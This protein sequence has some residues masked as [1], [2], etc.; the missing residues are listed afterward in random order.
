MGYNFEHIA[1]NLCGADNAEPITSK[2]KNQ[3]P[4]NVVLCRECGLG[5]LNP[6]W[7]AASYMA[8]YRDEYDR[9]Y[10]PK[11]LKT[12]T[13]D[14]NEKNAIEERLKNIGQLSDNVNTI[15]D[16]GSGEGKNIKHF[17]SIYPKSTLLAIEPSLES[18][19]QLEAF[20]VNVISSD[21]D[22]D[23]QSKLENKVDLIIMRHVLEHFMD[24]LSAMKKIRAA[25]SEKGIAYIAVPNNLKPNQHLESHWF[26]NVHTYYF[27][28][29]SLTNLMKL[30]GLE[31]VTTVEGD[32][33]NQHEVFIIVKKKDLDEQPTFSSKHYEEQ[34]AIFR[35]KLKKD[36]GLVQKTKRLIRS[37]VSK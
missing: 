20:G 15:L 12:E 8:F 1:C 3:L 9:H 6:R 29:Y 11:I 18:Q 13:Y 26:R 10:R 33:F 17:A 16:I 5:Y 27:N 21:V 7:N 14:K 19:R 35:N 4:T 30:A 31:L 34:L 28:A 32:S 24:P 25:L 23:W 36:R 22:S 2:G 37:L